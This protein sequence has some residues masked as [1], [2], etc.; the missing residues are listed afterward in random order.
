ML[1]SLIL[2]PAYVESLMFYLAPQIRDQ[3]SLFQDDRDH[4]IAVLRPLLQL[5]A[6][7]WAIAYGHIPDEDGAFASE[8]AMLR[9][10]WIVFCEEMGKGIFNNSALV[11]SPLLRDLAWAQTG[12]AISGVP[13]DLLL[14]QC[15]EIVIAVAESIGSNVRFY[16]PAEIAA[17]GKCI[18]NLR[19][20]P[21]SRRAGLSAGYV[22]AMEA[23]PSRPIPLRRR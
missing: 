4:P 11:K 19:E 8:L 14:E 21:R 10:K 1:G 22:V 12:R 3:D 17:A 7:E 16:N 2:G 9:T 18:E 20:H 13:F 5:R 15:D 6:L 23:N